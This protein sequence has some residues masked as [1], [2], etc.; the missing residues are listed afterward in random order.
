MIKMLYALILIGL[1]LVVTGLVLTSWPIVLEGVSLVVVMGV[2]ALIITR[3]GHRS[4]Q[5]GEH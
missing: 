1:A 3:R 5:L 2:L 4:R